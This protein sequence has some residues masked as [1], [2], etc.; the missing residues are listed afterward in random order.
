MLLLLASPEQK[1]VTGNLVSDTFKMFQIFHCFTS[2]TTKQK[3]LLEMVKEY[4][5]PNIYG[6][7][8][9]FVNTQIWGWIEETNPQSTHSKTNDQPTNQLTNHTCN[10]KPNC[11]TILLPINP[12]INLPIS[13]PPSIHQFTN[14]SINYLTHQ[15]TYPTHP[16]KQPF[17]H[18]TEPPSNEL[19]N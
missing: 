2:L 13:Y 14:H 4:N 10:N 15:P 11:Q 12:P 3:R 5:L 6:T 18:L 1:Y 19:T 8:R 9:D 7:V 16:T 17:Y